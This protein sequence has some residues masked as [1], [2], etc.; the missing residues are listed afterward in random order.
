MDDDDEQNTISSTI[1]S[2]NSDGFQFGLAYDPLD[3]AYYIGDFLYVC[4]LIF[5]IV[6]I[7]LNLLL[8][9]IIVFLK[10]L[11]LQRNFIWIGVGI[12]NIA[13]LATHL[14]EYLSVRWKTSF[15]S[16]NLCAVLL[17]VSIASQTWNFAIATLERHILL[18]Y[19]EWHKRNITIR[20]VKVVEC[21][22]FLFL[23]FLMLLL[24]LLQFSVE[25]FHVFNSE[26]F[27]LLGTLFLGGFPIFLMGQVTFMRGRI[28]QK[29]PPVE[30][31][32]LANLQFP[33]NNEERSNFFVLVGNYRVSQLEVKAVESIFFMGLVYLI[34]MV[35]ILIAFILAVVCHQVFYSPESGVDCFFCIQGFYYTSGIL[36]NL[37]SSIVNPVIFWSLNSDLLSVFEARISW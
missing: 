12:S 9:G 14:M 22:S 16:K 24:T 19:P 17:I 23:L 2:N 28:L 11:H 32:G 25:E 31:I 30:V 7:P 33:S 18:T 1:S 26:N 6:G 27:T 36:L 15:S 5:V 10:R 20:F 37:H 13:V 29:Y 8:V 34:L 35:P 4:Q 21:G 3:S